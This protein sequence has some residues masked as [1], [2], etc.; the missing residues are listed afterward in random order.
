MEV[1]SA[2]CCQQRYKNIR[3]HRCMHVRI[4]VSEL[5]CIGFNFNHLKGIVKDNDNIT[6][7]T[8]HSVVDVTGWVPCTKTVGGRSEVSVSSCGRYQAGSGPIKGNLGK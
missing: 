8:H 2:I 4:S 3:G 7:Q 6:N 1:C 5:T